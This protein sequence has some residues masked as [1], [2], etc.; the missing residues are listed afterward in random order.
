MTTAK[1]QMQWLTS[2][3]TF[4]VAGGGISIFQLDTN[5]V[6]R[7]GATVTRLIGNM[8]LR[9]ATAGLTSN[10]AWPAAGSRSR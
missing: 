8:S 2:A 4:T 3:F 6:Q 10:P 9:P 7:A 1:R 5:L